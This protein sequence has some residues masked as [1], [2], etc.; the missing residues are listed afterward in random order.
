MNSQDCCIIGDAWYVDKKLTK[1]AREHIT[2]LLKFNGTIVP[3][4]SVLIPTIHWQYLGE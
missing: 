2:A 1:E 4:G 3:I